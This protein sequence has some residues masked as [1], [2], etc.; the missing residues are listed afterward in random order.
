MYDAN[1]A[2]QQIQALK[3]QKNTPMY[4]SFF[5]QYLPALKKDAERKISSLLANSSYVPKWMVEKTNADNSQKSSISF[6]N[7]PYSTIPDS[8]VKVTDEDIVSYVNN[9]KEEFKQEE[10]RGIEYVT[11]NAAPTRGDS[12]EVYNQVVALK[13][14]LA[15]TQICSFFGAE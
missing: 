1:A 6:V 8:T 12:M 3:K 14:E 5:E 9:H 15:T 7:I 13:N 2:N 4:K 10:S 11:F